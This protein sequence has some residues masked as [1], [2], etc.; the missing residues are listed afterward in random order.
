MFGQLSTQHGRQNGWSTIPQADIYE[1]ASTSRVARSSRRTPI[2][3]LIDHQSESGRR[4]PPAWVI[5]VEAGEGRAP[6]REDADQAA[7]VDSLTY[8]IFRHKCHTGPGERGFDG[9]RRR[10]EHKLTSFGPTA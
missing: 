6:V 5:E 1:P 8:T 4:L 3:E 2:A 10:V 9:Q 7:F